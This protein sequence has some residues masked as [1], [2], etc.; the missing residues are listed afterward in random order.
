MRAEFKGLWREG[1]E[2]KIR[3]ILFSLACMVSGVSGVN[4]QSADGTLGTPPDG[5]TVSGVGV[6]SGYHC[7]SKDIEVFIDGV[8]LGKAGTGTQLL[9]TQGVC[10]RTDTG[11]SLLYNFNNLANGQ[12]TFS[13]Y[14][15]GVV[16]ASHTATTFQS[17]GTPWLSGKSAS[18]TMA[19]F[20]E[21]GQTATVQW[22]QS[23]QN[24]LITSI[25][26]TPTPTANPYLESVLEEP[27]ENIT[28][29]L[30]GLPTSP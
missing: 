7:S 28:D 24:F 13:V 14:A 27:I 4:A 23:Y 22:M 10:G 29:I 11:Y 21:A 1:G 6:I 16:F 18:Y 3:N 9:G 20:P 17:A 15:D 8:S 26:G 2:M 19:N 30:N 5:S 12:H 25:S